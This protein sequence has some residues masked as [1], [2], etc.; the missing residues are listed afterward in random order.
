MSSSSSLEALRCIVDVRWR[1]LES[2]ALARQ[3][4]MTDPVGLVVDAGFPYGRAAAES[5]L[6]VGAPIAGAGRRATCLPRAV[7]CGALHGPAAEL[8][9]ALRD[10]SDEPGHFTVVVLAEEGLVVTGTWQDLI[11]GDV[12]GKN[13]QPAHNVRRIKP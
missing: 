13:T 3:E 4:R 8:A 10:G 11:T 5:L 12:P 1:L 9:P 7:L 2:F 6:F